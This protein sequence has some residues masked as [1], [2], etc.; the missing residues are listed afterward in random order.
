MRQ[1]PGRPPPGGR[2]PA[3]QRSWPWSLPLLPRRRLGR[4]VCVV[5]VPPRVRRGLRIAL[6]RVLPLLLPPQRG[7][8]QVGP[9]A[10]HR[11]VAPVVEEVGAEH[12][13][14]VPDERVRTVPF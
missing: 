5:P 9:G 10:A 2:W 7:D 1:W 4:A 12:L 3:N 11:L 14:A 13:V 8:V 6:R